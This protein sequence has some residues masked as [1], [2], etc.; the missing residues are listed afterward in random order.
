V[1]K[2]LQEVGNLFKNIPFLYV[3]KELNQEAQVI[4]DGSLSLKEVVDGVLTVSVFS[5]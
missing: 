3:Y 2:Q 5:I 4:F 1:G